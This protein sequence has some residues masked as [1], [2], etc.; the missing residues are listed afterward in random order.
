MSR[1]LYDECDS[2]CCLLCLERKSWLRHILPCYVFEEV[3]LSFIRADAHQS[4]LYIDLG[5][6]ERRKAHGHGITMW[7]RYSAKRPPLMAFMHG[8]APQPG[9]KHEPDIDSH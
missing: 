9:L 8:T 4:R 3:A 5:T 1:S 6:L 2:I 7:V